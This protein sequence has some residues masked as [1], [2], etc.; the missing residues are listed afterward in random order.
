MVATIYYLKQFDFRFV[1]FSSH[2]GCKSTHK[3]E[4]D[5]H[6]IKK[7]RYKTTILL[8]YTAKWNKKI[9]FILFLETL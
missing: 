3:N 8:F 9:L 1:S 2:C 4:T 6:F 7:M 5:K